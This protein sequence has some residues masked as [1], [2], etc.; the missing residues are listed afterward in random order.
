VLSFVSRGQGKNRKMIVAEEKGAGR[1]HF[2]MFDAA[3]R[4]PAN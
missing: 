2:L 4:A 1:Q 3:S